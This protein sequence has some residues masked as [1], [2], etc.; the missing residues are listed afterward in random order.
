MRAERRR[1][2]KHKLKTILTKHGWTW[3]QLRKEVKAKRNLSL[4][5]R[6]DISAYFLGEES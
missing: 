4:T 3:R 6:L 2:L 5:K 1:E